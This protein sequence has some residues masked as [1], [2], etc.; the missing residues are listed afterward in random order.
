MGVALGRP[1]VGVPEHL[2]HGSEVGSAFEEV[3]RE[4]MAE[5]VGMHAPRLEPRAVG[6]LAQDQERAGACESSA[7]CVQEELR[8]I[9]TIEVRTAQREVATDGFGSR[10]PEWYE[11]LFPA[12]AEHADDALFDGDASFLEP[13]RLGH[14]QSRA[15][16]ELDERAIPQRAWRRPDGGVDEPFGLRR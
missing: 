16:Q 7:A 4:R 3:R 9:A 15:V 6:E 14:A 12:L 10:T 11:A 8:A 2:L 1:E 13:G 5:K